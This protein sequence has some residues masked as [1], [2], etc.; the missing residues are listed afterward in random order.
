MTVYSLI[1]NLKTFI[2]LKPTSIS[3]VDKR[4]GVGF[5]LKNQLVLLLQF[6]FQNQGFH[7]LELHE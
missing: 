6:L 5:Q 3:P 7:L 2:I 4:I 1:V